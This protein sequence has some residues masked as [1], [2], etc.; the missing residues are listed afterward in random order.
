MRITRRV[1]RINCARRSR[2]GM[3]MVAKAAGGRRIRRGGNNG[4]VDITVYGMHLEQ[5]QAGYWQPH[6]F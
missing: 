3:Q 6:W 5:D 2:R 1:R 4:P